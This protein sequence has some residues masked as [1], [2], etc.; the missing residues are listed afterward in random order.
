MLLMYLSSVSRCPCAQHAWVSLADPTG[1]WRT[2]V[3][4]DLEIGRAIMAELRGVG[5][6]RP[7][8]LDLHW[9][10]LVADNARA[11]SLTLRDE[12]GGVAALL[13]VYGRGGPRSVPVD[14]C[15]GLLAACRLQLPILVDER[16]RALFGQTTVPAV[17]HAVLESL[18]DVSP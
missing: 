7:D 18:G 12:D 8:A 3:T 15:Y 17:Y 5:S 2:R 6:D 11:V 14:L 4:V 10:A 1:E 9:Q 13:D 16:D